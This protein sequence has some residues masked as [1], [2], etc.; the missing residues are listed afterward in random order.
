MTA[1]DSSSGSSSEDE[2]EEEE[3]EQLRV[4]ELRNVG[5]S[6]FIN[7]VLQALAATNL[8]AKYCLGELERITI[9]HLY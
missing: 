2:D 1:S 4:T 7:S 9:A 8:L 3:L 6:C 5:N